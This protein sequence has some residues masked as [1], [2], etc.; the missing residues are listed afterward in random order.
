[1]I[2]WTSLSL[3]ACVVFAIESK[4]TEPFVK[5]KQYHCGTASNLYSSIHWVYVP[6]AQEVPKAGGGDSLQ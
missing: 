3:L 4:F 6:A 1:M 5:S 2:E